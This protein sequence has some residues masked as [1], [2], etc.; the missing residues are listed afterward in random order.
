MNK[1][2]LKQSVIGN[3]VIEE[4]E[5]LEE[6][7]RFLNNDKM[8]YILE[9][10]YHGVYV[11]KYKNNEVQFF[12]G[13]GL[14]IENMIELRIFD[15]DMEI[16]IIKLRGNQY[17]FRCLMDLEDKEAE[18]TDIFYDDKY[19]LFGTKARVDG[20]WLIL[21]DSR[22][23]KIYLPYGETFKEVDLNKPEIYLKVRN[24][25]EFNEEGLMRF[26]DSRLLGFLTNKGGKC[27]GEGA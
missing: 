12:D 24:Y 14:D 1:T 25:A 23:V 16:H 13:S 19:L 3:K 6:I 4:D 17:H 22:G 20:N 18:G 15:S 9:H 5:I 10:K 26:K 27:Y 7:R 11:G 8:Y 21:E 2:S